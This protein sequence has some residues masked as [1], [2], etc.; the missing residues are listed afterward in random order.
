MNNN[1]NRKEQ[2][3]AHTF[4]APVS[5]WIGEYSH[6]DAGS[7]QEVDSVKGLVIWPEGDEGF[8][9]YSRVGF[10]TVEVTIAS[11]DDIICGKV[12]ALRAALAQDRAESQ[13]RQNKLMK[14]ISELEALTYSEAA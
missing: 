12:E 7:L 10:G 8:E 14:Q 2:I 9:G 11:K 5:V 13:L 3:M 1:T 6:H 4:K